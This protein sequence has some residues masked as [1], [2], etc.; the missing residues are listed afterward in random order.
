MA[1]A[2]G[3]LLLLGGSTAV[4]GQAAQKDNTDLDRRFA[5]TVRPFVATYCVTCHGGKAPA[6]QLDLRAYSSVGDVVRDFP[7]WSGV[8][9]KLTAGQMPPPGT[10]QPPA[11]A[12]QSVIDWIGTLGTREARKNAG[13]PGVVLA[14]RLSNS[15]YNYTIRDLTGVDLR[16]AREFPVDPA[17]TAGF[18]NSGESLTMS[19]ALLNKYLQAARETANHVV[20]T[21]DG[22]SFAPF[23]MLVETDREKYAIQRI[24]DFY[25]KQPTDY[26]DYFEAAW[27][28][29][30]RSALR[31]PGATLATIAAE[32]NVSPKYLSMI[33]QLLEEAPAQARQE[34]GPIARLQAMWRALP[35]PSKG[36]SEP[37]TQLRKKCEEMRDFV[38]RIRKETA[39][40]YVAP[41]VKGLPEASQPLLNWKLR[42]FA[43]HRREFDP[44][45]L[46]NDTD[47]TPEPPVIPKYPGLHQESA[48]RWAALI[49][50]LRLKDPDLVVPVAER[51]RY[52][53]SFRRFASVFPDAFYIR[54]RGRYF[55]DDSQDKG[56]LLSAGYHS[57]LGYFRDDTP[58]ME[59]ILDEPARKELDRLWREFE[60]EADFTARTWVQFFFNQS[61]EVLGK[62]AESS[63]ERPVGRAIT[64][65]PVIQEMRDRYL[66]KA[67]ADPANDP[68]AVDAIQDH[69][70]RINETLRSVERVR[71]ESE[72]LH[73]EGL[74]KFTARAYRRPLT[75]PE[76]T[77]LMAFYHSL[78]E[79][80]ELTHEEAIRD[81]IVRVLMSPK[82][83]YR[84]DLAEA[85][86]SATALR[87]SPRLTTASTTSTSVPVQPL[88]SYALASR[89]S[90]FLWSSMPD[91][92]LLTH[93]AAGDL[94]KPEVLIQ[95]A[96][97]MLKDDRARG[98]AVEFGGNW[99][100]FRQFEDSNTVDR[101]RFPAFTND[102]REAMFQEPVRFLEDVIRNNHSVLDLLYGDYTFVNPILAKHYGMPDIPG[103]GDHW[104]RMDDA[105]RYGRGGVLPMAVFLTI[106]APGLRTSPVKRGNWLVKRVL[107]EVI[108]PP[109]P[110]VPELP[111]DES[112]L[113]LPLRQMLERHRENPLCASCHAR[114]DSFGLVF[115]GYGPTGERRAKDLAG[116]AVDTRAEF[117]GGAEGTG[118]EGVKQF[119]REHRQNDFVSNL[120]RELL[121][122]ALGR[123]L[124]LSDEPLV[125][126]MGAALAADGYRFRPL[127]DLI[128]TSPQ[129]TNKRSSAPAQPGVPERKGAQTGRRKG[130]QQGG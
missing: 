37:L 124:L 103:A 51:A 73:L 67:K 52:E 62:G 121:A 55:P 4:W 72:P 31:S 49:Q 10:K 90:Y 97:R 47:A 40:Q 102:L 33:W 13:D 8:Q 3:W 45:S 56:R 87:T 43:A 58:L 27:R 94:R 30:Y 74:A 35:P 112:K 108:P 22:L 88:S 12:R 130:N 20:F 23:P 71:K 32:R 122:Y 128:V 6:A 85:A 80:G 59:L 83:L 129:F 14:R 7:H 106:N 48:Y 111:A 65:V 19:P 76:R 66:A 116:H 69:F 99:L 84:I 78:R 53:A 100:A 70:Q 28:F 41:K 105:R 86:G 46:R 68:A 25:Q 60:Y 107:G 118:F 24:V 44:K 119:I 2:A 127:V 114:F 18:D 123:S 54:E 29:R 79:K 77:D 63:S 125:E 21:P 93:A 75:G 38:Q 115:E 50:T 36:S 26:A 5:E 96:H 61:G 101:E 113:D 16:P 17:N 89:L 98:L 104:V 42:E 91:E 9:A 95:Q 117:P 120:S 109:P 15:E 126:T 11:E 82:F 64:D 57:V 1:W 110:V 39:M 81:S 34:V 92:E